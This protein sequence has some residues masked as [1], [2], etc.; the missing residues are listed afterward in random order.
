MDSGVISVRY[1]RALLKSATEAKQEDKVFMEMETIVESY[2]QVPELRQTIENP[3]LDSKTKSELLKTAAGKDPSEQTNRFIDLVLK[4]GREKSLQFMAASYV[5]LYRQ[6][7]N[8][9]LG[10][11]I[12]ATAATPEIEQRIKQLVE[13]KTHKTVEFQ[14]EVDP[15]IIGGFILDYDTYRMDASVKNKLKT[16]LAELKK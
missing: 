5:T 11:L 7:K 12:T 10:K 4:E 16:V 13:N 1:A 8:I 9:T 2:L 14:T 6:Q 3:M 15:E